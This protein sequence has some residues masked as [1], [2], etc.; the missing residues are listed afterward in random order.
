[1]SEELLTDM[2]VDAVVTTVVE[3]GLSLLGAIAGSVWAVDRDAD[4]LSLSGV[5]GYP[6]DVVERWEALRLG[7]DPPAAEAGRGGARVVVRSVA[8]RDER[9]PSLRGRG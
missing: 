6:A 5:V 2:T 7:A 8:E 4:R 3:R 1:M 9:Y